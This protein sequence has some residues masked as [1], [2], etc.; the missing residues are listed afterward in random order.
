M[1]RSEAP[2]M[3]LIIVLCFY[4]VGRVQGVSRPLVIGHRGAAYLPELTLAAQ[5]MGY[6]FGADIIEIDVCLSRDNQLIVIHDIYLDGVSNVAEIFPNRNRSNGYSYVIDFDLEE[7]RRLT[8]RERFR[9]FNGTQIFPSR[10]PSNSVITFQLATLNETIELLLGFNRATGQQRQLLIEIKKPE[11]HLKYNKSISS[12]V[13]E[14][15]N[16]YNLKESSDPIILQTFHIE[17]LMHIRRNLGSK[18]RLFALM[19]WNRINESSSDYDFYRSEDGI[20]NLSNVIQ[21]IAP[22]HE[23]IVNYDSNGTILGNT[24][25]T[26]WAHQNG[27]AVYPFTFRRDSFPGRSFEQLIQYFLHTARVDGFITD[28]PDVILEFLRREMAAKDVIFIQQNSSSS[29][30]SSMLILVF[31]MIIISKMIV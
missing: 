17:E 23:F 1:K 6:A 15:L 19:T 4:V 18:L 28:H 8:I 7:L 20:R 2:A 11:Y 29:L 31:N 10:F 26:K 30:I 13:L 5:S 14:T 25:L 22:N 9:P 12:I 16:A 24:N 3:F 27:L 21:A